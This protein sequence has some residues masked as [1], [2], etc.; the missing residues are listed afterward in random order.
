MDHSRIIA[1][2]KCFPSNLGLSLDHVYI[3][4]SRIHA[5]SA[6]EAKRR[7]LLLEVCRMFIILLN[8][9]ACYLHKYPFHPNRQEYTSKYLTLFRNYVGCIVDSCKREYGNKRWR[10]WACLYWILLTLSRQVNPK[11]PILVL[12]RGYS[13]NC[14]ARRHRRK[15]SDGKIRFGRTHRTNT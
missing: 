7:T 5:L 13:N 8:R 11:L 12:L 2:V 9:T 15:E 6:W 14:S 10:Q 1:S 3:L 4:D